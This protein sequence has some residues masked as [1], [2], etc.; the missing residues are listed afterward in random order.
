MM[1]FVC[2]QMLSELGRWL[3]IAGYDTLIITDSEPDRAILDLA[4]KEKR[5]L[6]TRDKDFP[7]M[8]C[9]DG[10][11][12][13]LNGNSLQECVQDLSQK[14]ALNWL[15]APFSR[16]LLCNTPLITAPDTHDKI[17][18]SAR[19]EHTEFWLCPAC[20]HVFWHGSHTTHMLEQLKACQQP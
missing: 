10:T 8:R 18:P 15:H 3:R 11:V 7:K 13:Y 12:I 16:C 5:I 20:D 6:L 14:L 17:P 19:K 2:D 1:R 4:L 9:A